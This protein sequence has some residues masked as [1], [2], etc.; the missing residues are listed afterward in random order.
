MSKSGP[1]DRPHGQGEQMKVMVLMKVSEQRPSP[2][3]LNKMMRFNEELVKS[4]IMPAG[5]GLQPSPQGRR[6]CLTGTQR[7][8]VE[9]PFAA[10]TERVAGFWLWEV[11]SMD[12]AMAWAKLIPTPDH[13][14]ADVELRPV[15]EVPAD[16]ARWE[17]QAAR[18]WAVS[19]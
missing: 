1:L 10:M 6:L 19:P 9:G 17:G 18:C 11:S 15:L 12:E 4:G 13:G 7:T 14:A 2:A 8:L 16:A 3:L 5:H